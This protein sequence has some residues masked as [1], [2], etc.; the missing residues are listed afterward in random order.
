MQGGFLFFCMQG[1]VSLQ[2]TKG[3]NGTFIK[4]WENVQ[5]RWKNIQKKADEVV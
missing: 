3:K 2:K 4:K 5:N 1:F